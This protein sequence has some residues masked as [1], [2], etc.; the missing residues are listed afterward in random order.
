ML[1]N[2]NNQA[3]IYSTIKIPKRI[4]KTLKVIAL[5][6]DERLQETVEKILVNAISS[7][8]VIKISDGKIIADRELSNDS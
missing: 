7:Y 8:P 2:T 4:I 5:H 3:N 6:E 1:E